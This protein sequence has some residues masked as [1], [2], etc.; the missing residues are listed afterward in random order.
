MDGSVSQECLIGRL[1]NGAG[2]APVRNYVNTDEPSLNSPAVSMKRTAVVQLASHGQGIRI[3]KPLH[4]DSH[5][6]HCCV[7]RHSLLQQHCL[8]LCLPSSSVEV[9][10][11]VPTVEQPWILVLTP[12][13]LFGAR[14]C[15]ENRRHT[16][17]N[18]LRTI[19]GLTRCQRTVC[20]AKKGPQ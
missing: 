7:V 10:T 19:V 11:V 16:Q 2:P 17:G 14:A 15:N 13:A 9:L 20:Q 12:L 3:D 1:K 5:D 18:I 4:Q 8:Y 6:P